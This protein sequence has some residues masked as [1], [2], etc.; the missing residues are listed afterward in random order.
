MTLNTLT[1]E[2]FIAAPVADVFS[3]FSRPENLSK[4]TPP[5]LGFVI[6][7]PPPIEMKTG[8]LIDY[9]IRLF[10]MR[11]RWT[12]L[13]TAYDPGRSFVDEQ[14]KGPYSFWRHSHR[15]AEAPGGTMV[16]DEVRYALP[17]GP[18]GRLAHALV[19][20]RQLA[21]IFAYRE[22]A[23]GTI[24]GDGQRG[25]RHAAEAATAGIGGGR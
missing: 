21:S 11:V 2:Q 22:K 9:T 8:A 25:G 16:T 3:F 12:T 4:L 7:T 17:F 23:I 1:R 5:D 13:I 15:F 18:V 24:F 19:V 20:K 6:L 10:G 14:L